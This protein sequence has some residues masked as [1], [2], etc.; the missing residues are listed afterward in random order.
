MEEDTGGGSGGVKHVNISDF[1]QENQEII[2][3][4]ALQE[5]NSLF[6]S[7][8]ETKKGSGSTIND[9]S[10]QKEVPDLNLGNE[11]DG[12]GYLNQQ[13]LDMMTLW[14]TLR[15]LASNEQNTGYQS[16]VND[17]DTVKF[18]HHQQQG[19][20]SSRQPKPHQTVRMSMNDIEMIARGHCETDVSLGIPACSK[21]HEDC[22]YS[23]M[24]R[25]LRNPGDPEGRRKG[26][27]MI[28]RDEWNDLSKIKNRVCFFCHW[29]MVNFSAVS[30]RPMQRNAKIE[31]DGSINSNI[32][33]TIIALNSIHVSVE[34]RGE[35]LDTDVIT[36]PLISLAFPRYDSYIF[37]PCVCIIGVNDG[38]V[39]KKVTI[40]RNHNE[41]ETA[42]QAFKRTSN[43]TI[44]ELVGG[45]DYGADLNSVRGVPGFKSTWQSFHSRSRL[46]ITQLIRPRR[47]VLE[48][49]A[50]PEW[51]PAHFFRS[52]LLLIRGTSNRIWSKTDNDAENQIL[53][54][55]GVPFSDRLAAVRSM[56]FPWSHYEKSFIVQNCVILC[57]WVTVRKFTP[58]DP[59]IYENV[60]KFSSNQSMG[61]ISG[62]S[63]Q[64]PY[65]SLGNTEESRKFSWYWTMMM[66]ANVLSHILIRFAKHG[67]S[68]YDLMLKSLGQLAPMYDLMRRVYSEIGHIPNDQE[69]ENHPEFHARKWHP[70]LQYAPEMLEPSDDIM[71]MRTEEKHYYVIERDKPLSFKDHCASFKSCALTCLSSSEY[72][73]KYSEYSDDH[74]NEYDKDEN[75]SCSCGNDHCYHNND[76]RLI[77]RAVSYYLSALESEPE[78]GQVLT[79]RFG[80]I[81]LLSH[82]IT[83]EKESNNNNNI[84]L[85]HRKFKIK[86]QAGETSELPFTDVLSITFSDECWIEDN[87]P[88][89]GSAVL[90]MLS[91]SYTGTGFSLSEVSSGP[92][93]EVIAKIFSVIF[94][95]AENGCVVDICGEVPEARHLE[96]TRSVIGCLFCGGFE[97]LVNLPVFSKSPDH[98]VK[99]YIFMTSEQGWEF[100]N[101]VYKFN[102][103]MV[104]S[105]LLYFVAMTRGRPQLMIVMRE[106]YH[107]IHKFFAGVVKL[108]QLMSQL[109]SLSEKERL[110]SSFLPTLCRIFMAHKPTL[111]G[112]LSLLSS[113]LSDKMV[114]ERHK[115][116]RELSTF[117]NAAH[118]FRK[119]TEM[120]M[121]DGTLHNTSYDLF[122]FGGLLDKS[123][124]SNKNVRISVLRPLFNIMGEYL[125]ETCI[126]KQNFELLC[127]G[128]KEC[129][130]S[131]F[132]RLVAEE[133]VIMT[134]HET[135]QVSHFDANNH[136]VSLSQRGD[137]SHRG[138]MGY[139]KQSLAGKEQECRPLI[140]V[141]TDQN[142]EVHNARRHMRGAKLADLSTITGKITAT[143]LRL[144]GKPSKKKLLR[145]I[146]D[147][148]PS[149]FHTPGNVTVFRYKMFAFRKSTNSRK[150]ALKINNMLLKKYTDAASFF[151][152]NTKGVGPFVG[153]MTEELAPTISMSD[154]D[155]PST[156]LSV[157]TLVTCTECGQ[158]T[159]YG[160][161]LFGP[162]GSTNHWCGLCPEP[163]GSRHLARYCAICSCQIMTEADKQNATKK[164][165]KTDKVD[166]YGVKR[167]RLGNVTAPCKIWC[168]TNG[169]TFY[170]RDDVSNAMYCIEICD[171]CCD[172]NKIEQLEEYLPA[173]PLKLR[174]LLAALRDPKSFIRKQDDARQQHNH[175]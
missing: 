66:S 99:N 167:R 73:H 171:A 75:V 164:G 12:M 149:F 123:F 79:R 102:S 88:Q 55:L 175:R 106:R 91:E 159:E 69:F 32:T 77:N 158:N 76:V 43:E 60:F 84:P 163:T 41:N 14:Q 115:T 113:E 57:P 120:V 49:C 23:K 36:G 81:P 58:P 64:Y 122:L 39:I 7:K 9:P 168:N 5:V 135:L 148:Q 124:G 150:Q 166:N 70:D 4:R 128:I 100:M 2:I 112:F 6:P 170:A 129:G 16:L 38:R 172:S 27:A 17:P 169:E 155:H 29:V 25:D 147:L 62:I 34:E 130:I 116:F 126:T 74:T 98:T 31:S 83:R 104:V 10:P 134:E 67:S 11:K 54:L 97:C 65:H 103:I 47:W 105:Y 21:P 114:Q 61:I 121:F 45:D 3:T 94:S 143:N 30:M 151:S 18:H 152:K 161:H 1:F 93:E 26:V 111:R 22:A 86:N 140:I 162:W 50:G 133:L 118:T 48:S 42:E 101:T 107:A 8:K 44:F 87:L 109:I 173:T 145:S 125:S 33:P 59:Q 51:H 157:K 28:Y 90:K 131:L 117:S 119:I 63:N 19:G 146:K 15:A 68:Q 137:Y 37:Q 92:N 165:A 13:I 78:T 110:A 127:Q 136:Q 142:N 154:P 24:C 153:G 53:E 132:M 141:S 144:Q 108:A 89:Y 40:K 160:L 138:F 85:L 95:Y 56:G 96:L 80:V 46:S 35:F 71:C 52:S 174:A 20:S 82:V 139:I 156:K 72:F